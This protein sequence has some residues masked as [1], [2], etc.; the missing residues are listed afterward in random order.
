MP[1]TFQPGG[2]AT[3]TLVTLRLGGLVSFQVDLMSVR[4]SGSSEDGAMKLACVLDHPI[5]VDDAGAVIVGPSPSTVS[6]RYLCDTDPA[7]GPFQMHE[8]GRGRHVS[9]TQFVTAARDEIVAAKTGG[10]EKELME[11]AVH[12]AGDVDAVCWP[13]EK[14]YLLRPSKGKAKKVSATAEESYA[15]LR[16]LVAELAGRSENPLVMVGSLRL[17]DSRSTYKLSVWGDQLVL[18]ELELPSDLKQRDVIDAEPAEKAVKTLSTLIESSVEPFDEE[19]H[20]WDVEAAIEALV[21]GKA[22]EAPEP[23]EKAVITVSIDDLVA[24]ALG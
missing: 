19:I 10:L 22:A 18:V 17:G 16:H 1:T 8:L 11:L 7:H 2:R 14:G 6:Q 5:G 3:A 21:D 12:P 9:D 15:T 24:A 4:R 20:R 23:V 13:G